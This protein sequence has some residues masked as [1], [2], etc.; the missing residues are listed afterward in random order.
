MTDVQRDQLRHQFHLYGDRK[1]REVRDFFHR[2]VQ[3]GAPATVGECLT[4]LDQEIQ[5][6]RAEEADFNAFLDQGARS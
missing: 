3:D 4:M 1:L 2:W 6:R 5:F